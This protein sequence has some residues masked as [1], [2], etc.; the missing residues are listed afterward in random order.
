MTN[1][2][3]LGVLLVVAGGAGVVSAR[4]QNLLYAEY[5]GQFCLVKRVDRTTPQVAVDG[6][7]EPGSQTRF[8]LR[9]V[10][11]FT[12]FYV[13]VRDFKLTTRSMEFIGA[14]GEIN[15]EIDFQAEF[16]SGYRLPNVFFVVEIDGEKGGK[17]LLVREVGDLAPREPVKIVL[18]APL[19][20]STGSYR[21]DLHVFSNGPEV[22]NSRLPSGVMGNAIDRMMNEK[23]EGVMNA[24]PQPLVGPQPLYPKT[25]LGQRISGSATV[26]FLVTPAGWVK[27]PVVAEATDPALGE[28][29]LQAVKEWRFVPKVVNGRRVESRVSIPFTFAPPTATQSAAVDRAR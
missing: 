27:D 14:T 8:A 10:E 24:A 28:A 17:S 4:A 19:D 2:I 29:A 5:N 23:L 22:F 11:R 3:R 9:P 25:M 7:L 21:Y 12:P 15:N 26:T 1:L 6:K 20:Q 13:M 18:R 16:E